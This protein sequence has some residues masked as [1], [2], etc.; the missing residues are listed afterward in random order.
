[1]KQSTNYYV[2]LN[3]GGKNGIPIEEALHAE[4]V[5][6]MQRPMGL[7]EAVITFMSSWRKEGGAVQAMV[8]IDPH[9]AITK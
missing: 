3:T 2:Y 7:P 9:I 8:R 6:R 4:P 5:A 1:M